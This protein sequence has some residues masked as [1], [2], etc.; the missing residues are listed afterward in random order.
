MSTHSFSGKDV[1]VCTFHVVLVAKL[2]NSFGAFTQYKHLDV[3][4][5]EACLNK[6]YEQYN[7]KCPFTYRVSEKQ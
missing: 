2:R 1:H 3:K 6:R 7:S 5:L 4:M